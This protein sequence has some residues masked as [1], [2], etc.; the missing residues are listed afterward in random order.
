MNYI[1]HELK[2]ED[3]TWICPQCKVVHDRD[4]NAALNLYHYDEDNAKKVIKDVLLYKNKI[5]HLPDKMNK[6]SKLKLNNKFII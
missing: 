2:L 3:R 6:P 4:E 5:N 1:T